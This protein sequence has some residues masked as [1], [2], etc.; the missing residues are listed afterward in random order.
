LSYIYTS[1]V[2]EWYCFSDNTN[3]TDYISQPTQ[4][5][6]T[7]GLA[8]EESILYAIATMA[9]VS[10]TLLRACLTLGLT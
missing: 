3:S 8:L 7:L 4:H 5:P 9:E 6:N 10:I 1:A 2:G